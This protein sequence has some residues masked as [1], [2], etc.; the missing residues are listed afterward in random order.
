MFFYIICILYL[1]NFSHCLDFEDNEIVDGWVN[2]K[3][4]FEESK[5]DFNKKSESLNGNEILTLKK[6][7]NNCQFDLVECKSISNPDQLEF[8]F[9][10]RYISSIQRQ[11]TILESED[12][13]RTG[14]Y[15]CD[16]ELSPSNYKYLTEFSEQSS[17][18]EKIAILENIF[19]NIRWIENEQFDQIYITEH[20]LEVLKIVLLIV[21][22][23]LFFVKVMQTFYFMN[24]SYHRIIMISLILLFVISVPWQ[25]WQLFQKAKSK[26]MAEVHKGIPASCNVENNSYWTSFVNLFTF[27]QDECAKY[28]ENIE[29]HPFLEVTPTM[30]LSVTITRFVLEPAEYIGD[31]FRRFVAAIF[32]D[33]PFYMYLPVVVFMIV[34]FVMTMFVVFGYR[35]KTL[36]FSLEPSTDCLDRELRLENVQLKKKLEEIES[37]LK[38]RHALEKGAGENINAIESSTIPNKEP[39]K[40]EDAEESSN[41]PYKRELGAGDGVIP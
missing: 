10:K 8:R 25:W 20:N 22:S 11:F 39:L 9:F 3:S 32:T 27:R 28:F 23:A 21:L 41:I 2:P 26:K 17:S 14:H 30:A 16:I 40:I 36:L 4:L 24:L 38:E 1:F 33:L 29:V 12:I 18:T 19:T 37:K 35:L 15:S 6:N 5:L 13:A 7:L 31:A 34:I